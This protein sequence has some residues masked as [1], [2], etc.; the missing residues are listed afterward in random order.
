MG[1]PELSCS[2]M[3]SVDDIVS[4]SKTQPWP[5]KI[6]ENDEWSRKMDKLVETNRSRRAELRTF[7]AGCGLRSNRLELAL[8]E[9]EKMGVVSTS[10]TCLENYLNFKGK[11]E[12]SD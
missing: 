6:A 1:R 11:S 5:K 8:T 12:L 9:I 7:L 4:K 2:N 10:S 3:K